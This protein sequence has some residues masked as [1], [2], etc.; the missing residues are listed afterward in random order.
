MVLKPDA[1]SLVDQEAV[2]ILPN[3]TAHEVFQKVTCAAEALLLRAVPLMLTGRYEERPLDLAGGSYFGGR[4][5]EDGRVDWGQSA[6]QVHNLIRAVA[7]PYPGAFTDVGGTRLR[8]VGSYY[9][10]EPAR[11][12]GPRLYWEGGRCHADCADG[13]RILLTRLA[14]GDRDLGETEFASL[15]GSAEIHLPC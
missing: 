6:W 5:P 9:R 10:G 7:P 15:L 1:G 14:A 2:A 4:R 12:K 8:L 13:R 3:D 11:G